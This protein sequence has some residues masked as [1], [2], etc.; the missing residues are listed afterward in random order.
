ME[1][2]RSLLDEYRFP[3]F[4]PKHI[5]KG[6]FGDPKARIIELERRQKK[7]RAAAAGLYIAAITT[8]RFVVSATFLARIHAFFWRWRY[9]GFR[10]SGAAR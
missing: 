4:R 8:R 6:I 10:A 1:K 3:G 9:D 5:I 7:R 2:K